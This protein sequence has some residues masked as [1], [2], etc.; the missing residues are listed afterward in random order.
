MFTGVS[1]N[2]EAPF[3]F[4]FRLLAQFASTAVASMEQKVSQFKED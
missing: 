4:P 3:I 1:V 2:S